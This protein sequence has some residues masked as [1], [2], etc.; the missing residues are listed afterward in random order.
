MLL[1]ISTS[2]PCVSGTCA[3]AL[4]VLYIP[5]LSGLFNVLPLSALDLAVAAGAGALVVVAMELDKWIKRK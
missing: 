4:G 1:N 5:A 2:S 3:L